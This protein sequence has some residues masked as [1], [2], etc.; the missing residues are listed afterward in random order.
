MQYDNR[1]SRN[2]RGPFRKGGNR[3]NNNRSNNNPRYA[4]EQSLWTKILSFFGFGGSTKRKESYSPAKPSFRP[5]NSNH[6]APAKQ[7]VAEDNRPILVSIP[8]LYIGNL[9]YEAVESDLFDLFSQV[10]FVKNVSIIADRRGKSKGYG[11]V[12]MDSVDTAQAA[13]TKFN[14]YDLM[15]RQI[16]VNGAKE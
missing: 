8:K 6:S 2:R 15:G 10:G 13:A 7:Q 12:E 4:K 14:K 3:N 9:P 11:F 5:E 16:I 1:R